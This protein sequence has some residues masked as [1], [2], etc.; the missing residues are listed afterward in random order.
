MT[1]HHELQGFGAVEVSTTSIGAAEAL[2]KL[3]SSVEMTPY[4]AG[5]YQSTGTRRFER[6]IRFATIDCVK[7]GWLAKNKGVWSITDAGK[8]R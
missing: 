1:A 5:L 7:A 8:R 2:N 4:E 6:I 3:A